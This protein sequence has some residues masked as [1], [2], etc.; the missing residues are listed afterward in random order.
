MCRIEAHYTPESDV[1]IEKDD[2]VLWTKDYKVVCGWLKGLALPPLF[3]G[4]NAL[5]A[6][7]L[8]DEATKEK[9]TYCSVCGQL[10]DYP[11]GYHMAGAYC[12]NCW[13]MHKKTNGRICRI[14]GEPIW[15]CS[16]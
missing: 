2:I 15:R 1:R 4:M 10:M 9:M 14:C 3:V 8:L 5:E 16:C 7:R 11:A 6:I 13:Y 12:T